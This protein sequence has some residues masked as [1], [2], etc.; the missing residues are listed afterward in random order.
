M[1]P[2]PVT[3]MR[4]FRSG[5]RIR[6]GTREIKLAADHF[7]SIDLAA[8]EEAERASERGTHRHAKPHDLTRLDG[9][10]QR[11][12]VDAREKAVT[13]RLVKRQSPRELRHRFDGE[14]RERQRII[15]RADERPLD[16]RIVDATGRRGGPEGNLV[17]EGLKPGHERA[18]G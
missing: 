14:D 7:Y 13:L 4:V 15:R 2:I 5:L 1:M 18:E 16:R 12:S 6:L 10:V 8:A 3:A 11:H 9:P 17:R